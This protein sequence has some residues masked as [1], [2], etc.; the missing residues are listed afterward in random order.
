MSLNYTIENA[1]VMKEIFISKEVQNFIHV[2]A[3]MKKL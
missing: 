3:I 2:K 1:D